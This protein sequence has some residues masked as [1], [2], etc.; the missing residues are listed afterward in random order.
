MM[1]EEG[2]DDIYAPD[3]QKEGAS[4]DQ[5]QDS[6]RTK[7][8]SNPDRVNAEHS[9]GDQDGEEEEEED[10]S[11]SVRSSKHH[12]LATHTAC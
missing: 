8:E 1:D 7:A 9:E 6:T 3:D 11:D 12:M 2:D 4:R 10:D 5:L